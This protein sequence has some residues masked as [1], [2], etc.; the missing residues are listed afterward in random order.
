MKNRKPPLRTC[1]GCSAVQ[2]KREMLRIVR[3][4]EGD[5]VVDESGKKNGRGT[6]VCK[7]SACFEKAV[8]T[9][10]IEKSLEVQLSKEALAK[11]KEEFDAVCS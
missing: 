11:L 2:D 7:N 4:P 1:V 6:Y 9:K 3:T 10:K 8:K 5:V